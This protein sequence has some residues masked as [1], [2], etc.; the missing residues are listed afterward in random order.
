MKRIDFEDLKI[1]CRRSG[2]EFEEWIPYAPLAARRVNCVVPIETQHVVEFLDQLV[3]LEPADERLVWIR[4]WTIWNERSQSI[5]LRHL[6]LL[7]DENLQSGNE[8]DSHAYVLTG[9]E[10]REAIALLTVPALFG[11]DAHLFFKSGSIMVNFSPHGEVAVFLTEAAAR[12]A[13]QLEQWSR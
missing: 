8:I 12:Y 3:N 9:D 6:A 5:G 13:E 11:W 1:W 10:W 7:V 2:F 4:D